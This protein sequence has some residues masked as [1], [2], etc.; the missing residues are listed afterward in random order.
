MKKA[1]PV[2]LL[3]ALFV[4]PMTARAA[5]TF[6]VGVEAAFLQPLSSDWK[7]GA[8][9]GLGGFA[10]GEI[11]FFENLGVTGRIGYLYHF[12]KNSATTSETP[13]LFGLKYETSFGLYGELATGFSINDSN[14]TSAETKLG[15]MFGAG[16][17]LLGFNVGVNLF[18][19]YASKF[20]DTFG[21]FI[22]AGWSFGIL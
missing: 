17:H 14:H 20:S 1:I 6:N 3:A 10:K 7:R 19:P 21:L 22:L 13:V 9:F 2:L 16:V 12:E 18:S 8:G 4:A 15:L 11:F 5:N